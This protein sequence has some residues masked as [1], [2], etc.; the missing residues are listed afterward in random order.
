MAIRAWRL[1]SNGMGGMDWAGLPHGRA[2]CWASTDAEAL[3][4]AD[5]GDPQLQTKRES[6]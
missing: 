6:R 5:A 1:L 2:K 3:I 4:G